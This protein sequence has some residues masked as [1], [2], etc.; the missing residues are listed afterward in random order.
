MNETHLT[1]KTALEAWAADTDEQLL[2]SLAQSAEDHNLR[3]LLAHCDDGVVWGRFDPASK[4]WAFSGDAFPDTDDSPAVSPPLRRRTL[5]Q[6]RAFGPA[7]EL[8]I[9]REGGALHTRLLVEGEGGAAAATGYFD[10]RQLLW[11]DSVERGAQ[12]G[13]TLLREGGQGLRHG[14]PLDLSS[15]PPTKD[16][17]AALVV[18]NYIRH[19]DRH[20]AYVV[21]SRLVDVVEPG[22]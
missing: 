5:Q 7:A 20:V 10:R 4:T 9:W 8:F 22:K 12:S 1:V 2:Q 6:C 11:G 16:S 13:F 18:R 21:H 3:Y 19:D 15:A 17:R 14:V